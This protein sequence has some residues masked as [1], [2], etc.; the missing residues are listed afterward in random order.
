MREGRRRRG[1]V[2][3]EGGLLVRVFPVAETGSERKGQRQALRK[4]LARPRRE[5]AGDR[6]V[7]RRRVPED[8]RGEAA[9]RL[10]REGPTRPRELLG[11][12]GIVGRVAHDADVRVVLGRGPEKRRP[13]DVDLLDALGEG[14]AGPRDG[15]LE[16]VEV[17]DDEVDGGDPVRGRLAEVAVQRAVEEDAAE[18]LRMQRLH[19][20]AEDLRE[21]RDVGNARDGKTGRG[22]LRRRPSCRDEAEPKPGQ[23]ACEIHEAR[24]IR[25]GEKRDSGVTHG[26]R[27]VLSIRGAGGRSR[28][29]LRRRS[30][31]RRRG[32]SK[33]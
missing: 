17:H 18:E 29:R 30:R 27:A 25:D 4:F 6:G 3:I 8:L 20:A 11:D 14:H 2:D 26:W 12:R 23:D 16:R 33:A 28:R 13:A 9:A 19:P 15:L 31:S 5:P 21:T 1:R 22:E 7:V 24:A 10:V 32:G